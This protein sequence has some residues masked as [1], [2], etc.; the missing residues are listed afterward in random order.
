MM[1]LS[2]ASAY[3]YH[4]HNTSS[5]PLVA[6]NANTVMA[7]DSQTNPPYFTAIKR[8]SSW[9]QCLLYLWKLANCYLDCRQF[10]LIISDYIQSGRT[11]AAAPTFIL[12]AE[13]QACTTSANPCNANATATLSTEWDTPSSKPMLLYP[14]G[15]ACSAKARGG[16][17]AKTNKRLDE[18][19]ASKTT[20]QAVS[21]KALA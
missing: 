10:H 14:R 2:T 3:Q 4:W 17:Q 16:A 18:Y 7:S 11:P 9:N 5:K 15:G 6:S 13:I 12:P 1:K 19:S 20:S 21:K 8:P